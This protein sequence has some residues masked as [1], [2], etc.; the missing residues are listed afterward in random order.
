LKK[1]P[2]SSRVPHSSRRVAARDNRLVLSP[3]W[4]G[5]G[6][7][8]RDVVLR[9]GVRPP[10]PTSRDLR[11]SPRQFTASSWVSLKWCALERISAFLKR[12]RTGHPACPTRTAGSVHANGKQRAKAAAGSMPARLRVLDP[13]SGNHNPFTSPTWLR[14]ISRVTRTSRPL[15]HVRPNSIKKKCSLVVSETRLAIVFTRVDGRG[16]RRQE[17]QTHLLTTGSRRSRSCYIGLLD[18]LNEPT[19][20]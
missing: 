10:P 13:A 6:G 4:V 17:A 20:G 7:I 2:N 12:R 8:Q 15:L 5:D 1:A 19:N 14:C 16:V 3:G 9:P 11:P 18:V